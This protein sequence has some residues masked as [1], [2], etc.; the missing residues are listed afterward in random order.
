MA[1][2][3]RW[4]KVFSKLHVD[5]SKGIAPHKPILLLAVLELVERGIIDDGTVHLDSDLLFTY[6]TWWDLLV[7]EREFN[8]ALPFFHMR[9]ELFW[10][11][12]PRQGHEDVL[13]HRRQMRSVREL[14]EHVEC[15]R[16][17]PALFALMR[18]RKGNARLVRVLRDAYFGERAEKVRKRHALIRRELDLET[19]IL[20]SA[21][22]PFELDWRGR[23]VTARR[24]PLF[25]Q[26]VLHAYD[27]TCS[28]CR[29]RIAG[30]SDGELLDAAHIVPYAVYNN[31]D[32]RNGLCLCKNHHWAFDR[33]LITVDDDYHI[34]VSSFLDERRPTE[35]R[36][37][38]L[39]GKRI[40]IPSFSDQVHPAKEA[41]AWHRKNPFQE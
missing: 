3:N 28:V 39:E 19:D 14:R 24:N 37:T 20:A 38:E 7:R 33:G 40:R 26:F 5:R 10:K 15:A 8:I 21:S 4:L 41:L 12:V 16:L 27:R 2:V 22:G 35:W 25:R 6:R 9:S 32:V 30:G 36:L 31:D 17:D 29:L 23:A 13:A 1:D 11:L 34:M 18:D